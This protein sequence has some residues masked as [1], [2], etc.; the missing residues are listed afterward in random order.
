MYDKTALSAYI[1]RVF[2]AEEPVFPA[3]ESVPDREEP[4]LCG[5][6]ASKPHR[7]FGGSIA[8]KADRIRKP[9]RP[10]KLFTVLPSAAR[11]ESASESG[12]APAHSP[13]ANG[14]AGRPSFVLDESFRD[15]LLRIIGEKGFTEP[16]VYKRAGI[17]RRHFGKIRNDFENRYRP[18]KKTAVA[19]ALGLGLSLDETNE[20][21]GRAGYSLSRS[22]LADV[23]VMYFLENG[24]TDLDTINEALYDA[25]QQ[26]LT[27]A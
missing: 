3:Q 12:Y 20:F 8:E 27:D 9:H 22:I 18:S 19:L 26:T 16:E 25:D 11:E 17:D 15:A 7:L 10:E 1:E 4:V 14:S 24:V 2:L 5:E 13:A 21:I 23:I 6:N